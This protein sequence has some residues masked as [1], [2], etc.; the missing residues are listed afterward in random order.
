M[1]TK[2]TIVRNVSMHITSIF[3]IFS[4]HANTDMQMQN[5]LYCVMDVYSSVL[6]WASLIRD[7]LP[8]TICVLFVAPHYRM[9]PAHQHV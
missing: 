2:I 7:S 9:L 1:M 3:L 6:K 4:I 5:N 8:S